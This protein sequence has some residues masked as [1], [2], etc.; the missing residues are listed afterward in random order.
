VGGLAQ[1]EEILLERR[2][3]SGIFT[4]SSHIFCGFRCVG[5]SLCVCVC[6]CVCV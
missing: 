5:C 2:S 6:V 4:H 3:R 1:G